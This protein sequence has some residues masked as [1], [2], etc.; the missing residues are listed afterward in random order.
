MLDRYKKEIRRRG[1]EIGINHAP[2][3]DCRARDTEWRELEIVSRHRMT[4][5]DGGRVTLSLLRVEAWRYYSRRYQPQ[6]AS[7]AY[8]CG[9]DDSGLWAVR[10][11][12]TLK[13][14]SAAYEWMVPSAVRAAKQRGRKVLRQ[15]DVW[16]IET[17]RSHNGE[18]LRTNW[19]A[20]EQLFIEGAPEHV[21]A[22]GRW[23]LH[24]EHA[25]VQIPFPVRFVRNRQLTT[26]RGT[27]GD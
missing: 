8:L 5:P 20:D 26:R 23:L 16:A 12:G 22:P 25:P 14:V 2:R 1:G 3:R 4:C 18:S 11:P 21:W 27:A 6:E 17:S 9:Q 10:V 7:L 15:G 19:Y 13:G 24:P